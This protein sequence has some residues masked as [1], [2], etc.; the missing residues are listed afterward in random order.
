[1]R[2]YIV[3]TFFS[4]FMLGC[5]KEETNIAFR[6]LGEVTVTG[7]EEEY[8]IR[9]FERLVITPEMT[10]KNG[11]ESEFSFVWY[12][13]DQKTYL[14]GNAYDTISVEK[15]LDCIVDSKFINELDSEHT[16]I[17]KAVDKRTGVFHVFRTKLFASGVFGV[18]RI[19]LT[20]EGGKKRVDFIHDEDDV[21]VED[22]FDREDYPLDHAK[23]I[24]FVNPINRFLPHLKSIMILC[25]S[26]DGGLL[27]DP[28][29][30]KR[31]Y[32]FREIMRCETPGV[33]NPQMHF[34]G[35]GG[36]YD[37]FIYNGQAC[38]KQI[39]MVDFYDPP[40]AVVSN[41]S[42]IYLATM[43]WH[44]TGFIGTYGW[45]QLGPIYYDNKNH[46]FLE[47]A[48]HLRGY[49]R[50]MNKM[51]ESVFDCNNLGPHMELVCGARLQG[52]GEGWALMKNTAT[53]KHC[54][55]KFTVE[56]V[57]PN[58]TDQTK[59]TVN[60]LGTDK[61]ELD[62]TYAANLTASAMTAADRNSTDGIMIF[63]TS[64]KIYTLN[65]AQASSATPGN[66]EAAMVD[67]T[68]GNNNIE[69]TAIE[70]NGSELRVSV[71]DHALPGR[72]GGLI[73][74]EI[75][76]QGGLHLEKTYERYG[77]CDRVLDIEEKVS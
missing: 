23:K 56:C 77:F 1:M 27:L 3:L 5:V 20:E 70:F 66:I 54:I 43:A 57:L 29:T 16:L 63:A 14:E 39:A 4:L 36:S 76:T 10:F 48:V 44:I 75:S 68:T 24:V 60:F 58:I 41:P 67:F 74:Y 30:F 7:I 38:A 8:R 53:N 45:T 72:K 33:M 61:I 64:K 52:Q 9:M 59:V 18:G 50:Q 35:G 6:E 13:H 55:L 2:K 26:E 34:Q 51:S 65:V 12:V 40:F 42:D 17:F 47:H 32:T 19:L 69:I 31:K 21:L 22:V 62:G 71:I 28:T 11:E 25:D 46:R 15:N 37:Y 49:L 73:F